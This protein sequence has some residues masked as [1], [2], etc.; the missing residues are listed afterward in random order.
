MQ[1]SGAKT[2][3]FL[4]SMDFETL[5]NGA[6]LYLIHR[7]VVPAL[8]LELTFPAGRPFETQ[9]GLSNATLQ[10]IK[11]GTTKK[12]ATKIAE[13]L[14]HW[15]SSLNFDFYIDTC[16]IKLFVLEKYLTQTL[17]LLSHLLQHASF[18]NQEIK[19]YQRQQKEK[20]R[21][22]QSR[23]DVV[24]YRAF[25]EYLF[26][27]DHPYGYNS[28]E[29]TIEQ[30]NKQAVQH[31]Y[32]R[33]YRMDQCK[34]F[35]SGC[36]QHDS[37]KLVKEILGS[38]KLSK[39]PKLR[40]RKD[41]P[42]TRKGSFEIR[43]PDSIQAS[44]RIGRR[45]F[46]RD[47]PDYVAVFMLNT[48]LGG[49]YGS[50]LMQNL[51]EKKGLT[52]HIYSSNDTFLMDGYLLISTEVDKSR[53][54]VAIKEIMHELRIL[55]DKPIKSNELNTVKNYTLGNFLNYFENA[56]AQSEL[57]RILSLEGGLSAYQSLYH[58]VRDIS[59]HEIQRVANNYL[60]EGD[61]T[62]VKVI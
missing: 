52:Y 8:K 46:T 54:E 11:G 30:V 39:A 55:R 19:L 32:N 58:G 41:I 34:I 45:L 23:G 40:I 2:K 22:D 18:P 12:S 1:V 29:Q 17:P 31:F 5:P 43:H 59:A 50:R 49:F 42:D 60:Q 62:L 37:I 21:A 57:V 13:E 44:I 51:R 26:G 35:L 56:F 15:G 14:D 16:G 25:T 20:L 24:A 47:H 6:Q 7:G 48:L 36:F 28:T 3:T 4:P 38:L 10:L 53:S 27:A 9:K 61:L 33:A